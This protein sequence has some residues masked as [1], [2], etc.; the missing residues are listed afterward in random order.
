VE[1]VTAYV[2]NAVDDRSHR[3]VE[4]HLATR[5]GCDR[6]LRQIRWTVSELGRL[7]AGQ[8]TDDARGQMLAAF[9][10]W[11]C[12]QVDSTVMPAR[13]LDTHCNHR[14]VRRPAWQT[15]RDR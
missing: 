7:P 11:H 2:E 6:Y 12:E 15:G 3:R 1:L 5:V 14:S 4:E 10:G 13:R 8:L 9:R